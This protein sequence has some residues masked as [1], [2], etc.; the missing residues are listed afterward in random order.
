MLFAPLPRSEFLPCVLSLTPA[1]SNVLQ[2]IPSKSEVL[3]CNEPQGSA[4]LPSS[5]R[6]TLPPRQVT[7]VRAGLPPY[8]PGR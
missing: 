3:L 8:R 2:K 1:L 4:E 7:V 5:L 6:Q